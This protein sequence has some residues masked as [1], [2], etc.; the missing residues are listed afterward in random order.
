VHFVS[1]SV[2]TKA[3]P[4]LVWQVFAD[5]ELW[6]RYSDWLGDISWTS[7]E[8]WQVGSRMEVE[9]IRPVHSHAHRRL[10][11]SVPGKRLSWIDH[12]L[13]TTFEEWVFFEPIS[14]GATRN[15]TRVHVW[16]EFT[17]ILSVVA[18]RPLKRVVQDFFLTWYNNFAAEC[19]RR[20]SNSAGAGK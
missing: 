5:W 6:Y 3:N 10:Q 18:G 8:P 15:C 4:E 1:Y 2:E 19:D 13:G 14:I 16:A 9:M 17:G 11:V 12:I 20:A 7:G